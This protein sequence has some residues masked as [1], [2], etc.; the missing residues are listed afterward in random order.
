MDLAG[1]IQK[2]TEWKLKFRSAI[3]NHETMDV[4]T[5]ARDDRCELGKWLR[6]DGKLRFGSLQSHAACVARHAAF[7]AEA[8]KIAQAINA[9]RY[10]AAEAMLD[11]NMS[12]A[13]ASS[14]VGV[15]ILRLKKEA[16]L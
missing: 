3:E 7:H 8:G 14:D 2:H 16:A 12:Y 9:K 11:G 1:A 4:A 5:I 6:G 10:A 13:A 15:A